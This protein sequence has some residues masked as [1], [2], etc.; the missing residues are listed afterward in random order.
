MQ[1][2][3]FRPIRIKIYDE[4]DKPML[5]QKGDLKKIKR[6]FDWLEEKYK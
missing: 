1:N 6:I 5:N 3:L 2:K 4:N